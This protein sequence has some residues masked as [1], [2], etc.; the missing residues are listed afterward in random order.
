M[1]DK[2]LGWLHGQIK[3]PPFSKA[4]RSEA[5]TLLRRVQ[6]GEK[7]SMPRSRPMPVIGPRCHELRLKDRTHT[8]RVIYRID[9]DEVLVVDVFDKDTQETPQ[10]VIDA[11]K[12]RL[13]EY[14]A[15]H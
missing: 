9:A 8:W 15:Q 10:R 6:R 12:R 11:C 14:D 13:R 4:A 7:L 5:G 3:T 2:R 1:N